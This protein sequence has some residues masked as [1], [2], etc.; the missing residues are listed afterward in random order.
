MSSFNKSIQY[1]ELSGR[2]NQYAV[3]VADR[4]QVNQK[5]TVN[6][7]LRYEYYPLMTRQDRGIER[8]DFSTFSVLLGGRGGNPTDL[9]I[10]VSNTL[11]AP[12]LGAAYRLNEKTVLRAGY[13]KT[14]SIR[15]PGRGQ[16]V[17]VSR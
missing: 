2:E 8:L 14:F 5:F 6:A 9:G 17:A 7:G 4:W 16:C 3:Y 1:E 11:F 10:K 12:R 15:C 13:G